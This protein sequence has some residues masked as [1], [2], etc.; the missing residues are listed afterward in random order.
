MDP[1]KLLTY[2]TLGVLKIYY[3]P[4]VILESITIN[5]N[6]H[7][8]LLSLGSDYGIEKVIRTIK[9]YV[10]TYKDSKTKDDM[11]P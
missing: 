10:L 6:H 11:L 4:C 3:E 8:S 2:I 5:N 9:V 7:K 1:T